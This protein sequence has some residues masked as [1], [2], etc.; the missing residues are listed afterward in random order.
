MAA[1]GGR[2]GEPVYHAIPVNDVA[3]AALTSFAVVAAL[4]AREITGEGQDIETSLAASS[5]FYQFGELAWFEGRPPNPDGARDCLGFFALDRYYPCRDGWLTLAITTQAQ[6][7]TLAQALG[8]P[9]WTTGRDAGDALAEPRDGALAA[10]I[11]AALAEL[12]RDE[13][14]ER[15]SAAGVPAAPVLR[16]EEAHRDGFLADNGYY[17]RHSDPRAGELTASRGFVEFVGSEVGFHRLPPGLGA[18]GREALTEYGVDA[19]RIDALARDGV[20]FPPTVGA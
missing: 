15:L 4:N 6:F 2:G 16:D 12:G 11:A 19:A 10:E 20:I 7:A 17:Q 14:V 8:R 13:A 9:D 5:A 3:T 18:D 1:Q